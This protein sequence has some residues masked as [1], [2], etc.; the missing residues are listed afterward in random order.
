M[1]YVHCEY[2]CN[3]ATNTDLPTFEHVSISTVY[4]II[5]E[6]ALLILS[7][8]Q[9]WADD[10]YKMTQN[11]KKKYKKISMSLLWVQTCLVSVH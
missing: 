7:A 2:L 4:L 5:L 10:R 3:Q 6:M 11:V 9:A 8:R 1:Q